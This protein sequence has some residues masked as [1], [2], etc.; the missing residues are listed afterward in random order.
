MRFFF[1][2]FG[3]FGVLLHSTA[4]AQNTPQN[5]PTLH[6]G[7][8]A[9]APPWIDGS[10]MQETLH[11]LAWQLPQ[12]QFQTHFYRSE[13]LEKAII[14][15]DVQVIALTGSQYRA[16][17][18]LGIRDL[19]TLV[20]RSNSA[21]SGAAGTFIVRKD[22]ND[23]Q[24]IDDLHGLRVATTKNRLST[25]RFEVSALIQKQY[26]LPLQSFFRTVTEYP[27]LRM[28]KII[29][30]VIQGKSDVGILR[31]CFLEDLQQTARINYLKEVK[32]IAPSE[33]KKL[34]CNHS[35]PT[36]PGWV[37]A[38]TANV[39]PEAATALTS[40]LLGKTP[41]SWGQAW[42]VSSDFTFTDQML[43]TLKLGP[44]AYL[45]EWTLKRVWQ[46]YQV[47]VLIAIFG[48]FGLFSH[49][50]I[51]QKQVKSRTQELEKTHRRE[52]LAMKQ[53][54]E[55]SIHLDRLQ[56]AG[57]VGQM[58]SI[59]AH[60]MKQPLAV[61]Q[62]LCRGVERHLEDEDEINA[63]TIVMA[64]RNIELEAT[65]AA[66]IV[67]RVRALAKGQSIQRETCD[68][69]KLVTEIIDEIKRSR[70]SKAQIS[71]YIEGTAS[72]RIHKVD[73]FLIV[74]NLLSNAM[75]AT[76]KTQAPTIDVFVSCTRNH[77]QLIVR[78][79]GP[80]LSDKRIDHLGQ[81]ILYSTKENG[82]GLGV[83]IIKTLVESYVGTLTYKKAEPHGLLAIVRLP[84]YSREERSS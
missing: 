37:I 34:R 47:L 27:E 52:R 15:G 22:R 10:F 63:D 30:D 67:N 38:V 45:Q 14:D 20:S 19:A 43:K 84:I 51:L 65:R 36:H 56:R 35:T 69:A 75:D 77:V 58:S 49:V 76:R 18:H 33:N 11:H 62:N 17:A 8:Q 23:L 21:N 60:E 46:E 73:L 50:F 13:D 78:D 41:N 31:A 29:E 1:I 40:A 6:I 12:Y 42:S 57:V 26:K 24:T 59:V 44:F 7:V 16:L 71:L 79:N 81:N 32:V 3:V 70:R 54:H 74:L 82:L 25:G 55:A 66:T 28:R 39:T 61:I 80:A 5:K 72:V 2:L 48:L 68:F 83:S 53:A 9:Y 64:I 4:L